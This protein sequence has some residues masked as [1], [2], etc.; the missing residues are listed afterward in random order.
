MFSA[1]RSI[2]WMSEQLSRALRDLLPSEP[3]IVSSAREFLDA[4]RDAKTV[5]FVDNSTIADL[6]RAAMKLGVPV[7][8]RA[9]PGPLIAICDEPLQIAIGWLPA[10]PWLSHVVS[11][12]ML[13]H[14]MAADHLRNV[15]STLTKSGQPRLLDWLGASVA[16]RRVRLAHASRRAERLE[17]MGMF[18]DSKGVSSRTI[19]LL[20]D[21][22]EELLTNAFYDAP[23]AAGALK[24]PISRTQD[25]SLPDDSACDMVYGCREDLA[26]VRV[27]D[28]FGSLSRAR[29]VEVLTRCARTDMGVEVDETMGGA[30][31]G[32][33]RVFSAASFVAIAVVNNRHTEFLVG[34]GKRVSSKPR[35]FAFH[36]FFKDQ[37]QAV[38][39]WRLLD[40]DSTKPSVNRSVTIV[41]K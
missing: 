34:I 14:P 35:P 21:A 29:L 11:S 13:Q 37:G 22:A 18:F 40:A 9:P 38:R 7:D 23:V 2:V 39:R 33:W 6:D 4:R 1:V 27:R 26:I 30:G 20:R 3:T 25:V 32:L 28:P 8:Q 19:E 31:L 10:H 24:Q 36:L 41:T 16:A 12:A 5:S 17:R 15:M